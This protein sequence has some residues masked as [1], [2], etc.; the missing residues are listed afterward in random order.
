MENMVDIPDEKVINKIYLIW[1]ERVMPE[2]DLAE[3]YGV[4]T[5]RLNEQVKRNSERFP[6]DFMFELTEKEFSNLKSQNATSSWGGRRTLPFAFTDHGVLMLSS[7]LNS[8][9]AIQVNIRIMRV[10][11]K[12]RSMLLTNK[13]LLLKFEQV[14]STLTD[15]D[16]KILLILDYL[17]KLEQM[18]Q[19]ESEQQ[20]RS[21]IGFR[22]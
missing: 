2:S 20:N 19:E 22:E 17:K 15:H 11:S 3:L 12:I 4:E 7:V 8:K 16:D 21:R 1:G 18:K 5:K 14:E 6:L 10:Y 13:E 9:L